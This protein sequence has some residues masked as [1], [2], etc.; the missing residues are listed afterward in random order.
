MMLPQK[1]YLSHSNY[2]GNRRSTFIL[3]EIV[4]ADFEKITKN[5]EFFYNVMYQ[6]TLKNGTV[7]KIFQKKIILTEC[8][9]YT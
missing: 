4:R 2:F 3:K 5:C 7:L 9:N 8:F 1:K 6:F